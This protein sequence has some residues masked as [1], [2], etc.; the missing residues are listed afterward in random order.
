MVPGSPPLSLQ[1]LQTILAGRSALG[2]QACLGGRVTFPWKYTHLQASPYLTSLC[3][4]C[5][6]IPE[7]LEPL[8]FG[9]SHSLPQSGLFMEGAMNTSMLH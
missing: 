7:K 8:C 4:L 3:A 1:V 2:L 5:R 6:W 9:P